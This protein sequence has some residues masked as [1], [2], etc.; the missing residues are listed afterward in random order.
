MTCHYSASENRKTYRIEGPYLLSYLCVY[1]N[2]MRGIEI[3]SPVKRQGLSK[4]RSKKSRRDKERNQ[5]IYHGLPF[6]FFQKISKFLGKNIRG[7]KVIFSICSIN[8]QKSPWSFLSC[9]ATI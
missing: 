5:K 3:L 1:G 6:R 4:S 8:F 2:R 7:T 9:L